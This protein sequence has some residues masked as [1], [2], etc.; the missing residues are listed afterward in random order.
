MCMSVGVSMSI[1]L[2][3]VGMGVGRGVLRR[4]APTGLLLGVGAGLFALI[5]LHFSCPDCSP[6]HLL[7]WHG[8]IPPLSGAAAGLAWTLLGPE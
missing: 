7:A 1:G 2:V 6:G 5:P 8:L 3:V 4:H